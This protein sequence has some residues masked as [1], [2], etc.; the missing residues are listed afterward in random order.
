MFG[1]Y[2][3]HWVD[4]SSRDLP[5]QESLQ[6]FCKCNLILGLALPDN[7]N[8][9]AQS[10]HLPGVPFISCDVPFDLTP[11]ELS[12]AFRN[13][14]PVTFAMPVPKTSVDAN[15]SFESRENYVRFPREAADVKSKAISK[16]VQQ[17]SDRHFHSGI[18]SLYAGH[19]VA[20][21]LGIKTIRHSFS[22]KTDTGPSTNAKIRPA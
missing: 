20:A 2:R 8:L 4:E 16:P 11:P 21:S 18:G 5:P 19:D 1:V 17:P 14:R 15:Y 12:V 6:P 13:G 3:A 7:Q 9:P 10:S 22:T